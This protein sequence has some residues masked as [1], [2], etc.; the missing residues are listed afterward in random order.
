MGRYVWDEARE[1]FGGYSGLVVH[2]GGAELLTV[3]DRGTLVRASIARGED[4]LIT[5]V[6][7]ES[8]TRL[9]DNFGKEVDGFTGDA[10]GLA[11]APDGTLYVA[12]ESYVRVTGLRLPDRKPIPL[13]PWDRFKDL[14]GNEAFEGIA[15]LPDGAPMVVLEE[16]GPE[17]YETLILRDGAWSAGPTLPGADG[18]AASDC[19]VDPEGRLY[20]LERSVSLIGRFSTRIR[21][22]VSDGAGFGMSETLLE[23][24][25][26]E[27]DNMEGMALWQDGRGRRI[28]TLISD[29][30][31]RAV[32][33]TEI[34]EFEVVE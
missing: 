27:M 13:H 23:T 33:N 4:G 34:A 14:W 21:R 31:F 7:T 29:D 17:G 5:A 19:L 26:G 15:V 16:A 28:L 32:Q 1:S 25:P 11:E 8:E 6:A 10:E 22:F 3:S 9:V 2:P 20:L 18:Y 24:R 30:N 12:Y